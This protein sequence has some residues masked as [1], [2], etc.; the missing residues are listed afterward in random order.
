MPLNAL[1][2]RYTAPDAMRASELIWQSLKTLLFSSLIT[3]Q[4]HANICAFHHPPQAATSREFSPHFVAAST[5]R[6]LYH[7]SFIGSQF[8]GVAADASGLPQ[9]K[10]AFFGSLDILS[11]DLSACEAFLEAL[12]PTI[13]K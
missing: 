1:I 8:G 7:L 13:G 5:L 10:R 11:S 4:S 2:D 6:M 3:A 9:Q 12:L